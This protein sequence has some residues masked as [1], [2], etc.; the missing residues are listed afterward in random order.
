MFL[1][2]IQVGD[3]ID[4]KPAQIDEQEMMDFSR[5]FN[6]VP[7]HVDEDYAKNTKFGKVIA[8]GMMS[9]LVVW[10]NYIPYDFAG[11]H[12]IA[13]KSSHIEWFKPV[14]A[15]DVLTGKATV[16]AV[17]PRNDYNGILEVTID[18]YNQEDELVLKNVTESIVR[19][20]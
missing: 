9:F 15:G 18:I 1:D 16:T 4:V 2:E 10:A 3:Y 17:K 19:R 13:G 5:R 7:I 12:L 11:E 20:K 8:S 6:P 14:F